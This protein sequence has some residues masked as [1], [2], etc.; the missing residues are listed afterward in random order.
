VTKKRGELLLFAPKHHF[1]NNDVIEPMEL[2]LNS[3]SWSIGNELYDRLDRPTRVQLQINTKTLLCFLEPGIGFTITEQG[4]HARFGT[5][6]V[7]SAFRL[8]TGIPHG[9]ILRVGN[10][11]T[12]GNCKSCGRLSEWNILSQQFL[13]TDHWEI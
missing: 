1:L 8:A 10:T 6:N 9:T 13:C 11:F 7:C 2:R 12:G 4:I 5:K 3:S